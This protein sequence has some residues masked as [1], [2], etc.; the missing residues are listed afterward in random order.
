MERIDFV[1][2][3]VYEI[4]CLNLSSSTSRLFFVSALFMKAGMTNLMIIS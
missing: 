3:S 1:I 2:I 4:L